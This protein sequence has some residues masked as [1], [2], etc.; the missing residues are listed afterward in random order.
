MSKLW[1][2]WYLKV[3][4]DTDIL[5]GTSRKQ[6]NYGIFKSQTME[7]KSQVYRFGAIIHL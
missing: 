1:N 4:A 3:R 5:F 6:K 2:E 7:L